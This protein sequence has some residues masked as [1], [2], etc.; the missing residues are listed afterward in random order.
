MTIFDFVKALSSRKLL[1]IG[2]FSTIV[3]LGMAVTFLLP[4]TYQS[5]MKILVTR[6]RVDPLVTPADKTPDY[7]RGELTEEDFN[8]EIE[9]LRSRAVLEDVVRQLGLDKRSTEAP[10]DWLVRVRSRLSDL[11]RSFH[12]QAA[13][14]ATEVAVMNLHDN[15]EAISVKKSRIIKVTCS[16]SDP[17]RAARILNE[18]YRQY[19]EHHLRLLQNS[20]AANVFHEQSET[21]SRK[22]KDATEALKRFDAQSETM[23]AGAQQGL[24]LQRLYEARNQLDKTRTEIR[25]IERRIATL[26]TQIEGQPE[27]IESEARTKYVAAL[28][29]IKDEILTLELQRTQLLQKYQPNHRLVK[30]VEE[31][32]AQ[33]R[34]LL[35]REEKSPPEERAIVLNEIRRNLT[36]ELLLAEASLPPLREREER[37]AALAETYRSQAARFEAKSLERADLER[38]RA[39]NEE[40]YLL[41][42][43]KAQETDIINALNQE[44]IVNFSLAEAPGVNRTPVSPKPLINLAALSVVGLAAAIAT[45]A[46]I[47]RN[48]LALEE[49]GMLATSHTGLPSPANGN[50]ALALRWMAMRSGALSLGSD[51][52][53]TDGKEDALQLLEQTAND[54]ANNSPEAWRLKAVVDYL[55]SVF[56]LSSS[57]LSEVLRETMGWEI[58]SAEIDEVLSGVNADQIKKAASSLGP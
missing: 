4:P 49:A 39:L 25:E 30:E 3:T 44:R 21:F 50:R 43:K 26:K 51:R 2:L 36:S 56:R 17:E 12:R 54:S 40:A 15:L 24:L 35:A 42:R 47:E 31:R 48:R 29:K 53:L 52:Q 34:D 11:Y 38:A 1:L 9:I 14:D 27:R 8:S 20:K 5:T 32:L 18:L 58:S 22:L 46:F 23:G 33:A 16:D 55:H 28:D 19:A 37:L 7:P 6:D 57:E 10:R 13:P 41:Y 45:V